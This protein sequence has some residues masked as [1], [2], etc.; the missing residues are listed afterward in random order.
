MQ[1]RVKGSD[2]FKNATTVKPGKYNVVLSPEAGVFAHSFGHKSEADFML[3]D[4]TMRERST[5]KAG[6][7]VL[8]IM[9]TATTPV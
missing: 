4:E 7:D 2:T 9:V 5:E 6:S 8:S 1:E 3:G